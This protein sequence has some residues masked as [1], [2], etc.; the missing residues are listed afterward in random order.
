MKSKIFK[1][2]CISCIVAFTVCSVGCA[3]EQKQHHH[4]LAKELASAHEWVSFEL[5]TEMQK[6]DSV[7]WTR[8]EN[9]VLHYDGKNPVIFTERMSEGGRIMESNWMDRAKYI[10]MNHDSQEISIYDN[11]K[12][13]WDGYHCYGTTEFIPNT[14]HYLS[15]YLLPMRKQMGGGM[16]IYLINDK[17]RYSYSPA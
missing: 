5:V 4:A 14:F 13:F 15:Y 1:N 2:L 8:N 9:V 10:R 16:M 7:L 3:K 17:I 12:V 11:K 6:D